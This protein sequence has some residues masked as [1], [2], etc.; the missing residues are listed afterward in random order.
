M[1]DDRTLPLS[2][3]PIYTSNEQASILFS[4]NSVHSI[5]WFM[6]CYAMLCTLLRY[7]NMN[8]VGTLEFLIC[9]VLYCTVLYCDVLF[10]S[11]LL[12]SAMR[13]IIPNAPLKS[14]NTEDEMR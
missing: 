13:C 9:T 11:A 3:F 14:I 8:M 10:C 6:L 1:R 12:C 4:S 7:V 5:P 2:Y